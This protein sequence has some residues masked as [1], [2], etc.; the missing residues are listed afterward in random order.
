MTIAPHLP[1]TGYTLFRLPD[2]QGQIGMSP[3][4]QELTFEG[5]R[6]SVDTDEGCW[7]V[8]SATKGNRD[9]KLKEDGGW[10]NSLVRWHWGKPLREM[11]VGA[12][13]KHRE[14]LL[15]GNIKS[16]V[17]KPDGVQG[18]LWGWGRMNYREMTGAGLKI[19][20]VCEVGGSYWNEATECH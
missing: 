17:L 12:W 16:R 10:G 15:V 2:A 5:G 1:A 4:L 6:Q 14:T 9:R 3:A 11:S 19:L 18:G 13:R 7:S 20:R 8:K